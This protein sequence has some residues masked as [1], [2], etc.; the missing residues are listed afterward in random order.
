MRRAL[1]IMVAVVAVLLAAGGCGG[2]PSSEHEGGPLGGAALTSGSLGI[3]P[4]TAYRPA[5]GGTW[6]AVDGDVML[7]TTS[8]RPLVLDRV[9]YHMHIGSVD[10]VR[11]QV[12]SVRKGTS[13]TGSRLGITMLLGTIGHVELDG[14]DF[15]LAGVVRPVR[16]FVVKDRCSEPAD[17]EEFDELLIQIPAGPK[18]T[19]LQSSVVHYHVGNDHYRA[20]IQWGYALLGAKVVALCADE[21]NPYH[22]DERVCPRGND[23]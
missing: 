4:P 2:G 6:H 18:G 12:R 19:W 15:P 3:H 14:R 7:C 16:G 8:D 10:G 21:A 23:K 5:S 20:R 11:A 9:T 1:T 13:G 22:Q 17:P